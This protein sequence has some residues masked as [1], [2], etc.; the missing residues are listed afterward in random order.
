[1]KIMTP[2][3]STWLSRHKRI[4]IAVCIPILI[5]L[6]WAF[7]PEKLWINQTVNEPAPFDTSGDPE[8][9]FT[10]RFDAKTGGR[11]T[12]FKKPGGKE[13]LRFKDLT[14]A[15][16]PDAH[17][18]LATSGAVSQAQNAARAELDG[19]DLGP[20]KTDQADQNYNLPAATDLTKY[21]D[22][23]IYNKRMGVILSSA[24]LEAF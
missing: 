15:G 10:G 16:D 6:W 19:I 5:A 1:M 21:N 20:L 22:V 3:A 18:E 12:V 14:V 24:K 23:V 17:V 4:L 2:T 9:I 7:R 8:P 11:I 13:Y